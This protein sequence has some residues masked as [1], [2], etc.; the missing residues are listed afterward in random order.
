MR[1]KGQSLLHSSFY[2]FIS[3][4]LGAVITSILGIILARILGPEAYG[5][6]ALALGVTALLIIPADLG[7]S[8]ATATF[9]AAKQ[10]DKK[11]AKGLVLKSLFLK[12][13]GAGGI[14]IAL[15]L[16]SPLIA[17]FYEEASLVWPLRLA[18]VALFGQTMF[19]LF[20]LLLI[21][22]GRG[23]R[24]L[25][26]VA[27]EGA[28]EATSSVVL[29]VLFSTATAAMAGRMIGFLAGAILGIILFFSLLEKSR[30][31]TTVSAKE[32]IR[33][34]GVMLIIDAAYTAFT[35]IDILIIGALLDS[36]A[37]AQFEI[38]LRIA[39]ALSYPVY[40]LAAS[41]APRSLEKTGRDLIQSSLILMT[42]FAAAIAGPAFFAIGDIIPFALGEA[43]SP[44][45]EVFIAL[46]PYLLII[47]PATLLVL[48]ANYL[49]IAGKRIWATVGV[50]IASAALSI[51]LIEKMGT[52]GAAISLNIT[53]IIYGLSHFVIIEK[54]LKLDKSKIS[55]AI[56][57][58]GSLGLILFIL[59][60]L[61]SSNIF[62]LYPAALLGS[63]AILFVAK[64]EIKH[65]VYLLRQGV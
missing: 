42:V 37:V 54:R 19:A 17:D 48:S 58:Y 31:K 35:Q 60:F 23:S 16:L 34:A 53:F 44:A 14:S 13:I 5:V 22:T 28:V 40:A 15:F 64:D 59:L 9:L 18:A 6:F 11:E 52:V 65:V 39:T 50:F 32:I 36:A 8:Q 2:L 61:L 47:G 20:R 12:S 41:I 38:P 46:I 55:Q 51:I 21:T 24:V 1:P 26:L 7:L 27:G 43:Y 25:S 62:I 56:F 10:D 29:V 57:K 4:I 30:A 33:F 45:R 63:L 49:S 3:L